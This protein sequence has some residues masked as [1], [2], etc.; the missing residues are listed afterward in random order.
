MATI[1]RVPSVEHNFQLVITRV[2][3]DGDQELLEDEDE[4]E[5]SIHVQLW[6][7]IQVGGHSRWRKSLPCQWRTRVPYWRDRW[8]AQLCVAWSARRRRWVLRICCPWHQWADACVLWNLH[9]P[10]YVWAQ[11]Q[12]K[13]RRHRWCCLWRIYLAVCDDNSR[14][15][16]V[17]F[18]RCITGLLPPRAN[19]LQGG[20]F[21][22]SKILYPCLLQWIPFPLPNHHHQRD[23]PKG[24]LRPSLRRLHPCLLSRFLSPMKPSYTFGIW[25]MKNSLIKASSQPRSCNKRG[26]GS[27][28]GWLR[29]ATTDSY[30]RTKSLKIWTSAGRIRCS[31]SPG[32][33][34][35]IMVHNVVGCS[36]LANRLHTI[37]FSAH[38][39][40]PCGKHSIK[41]H[42]QISRCVKCCI[43][44]DFVPQIPPQPDEQNYILSSNN[45]DVEMLDVEDEEEDEEEV[46]SELDPDE[47]L[48]P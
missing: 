2:Y 1:R 43:L 13:C 19:L 20:K 35:V 31:H 24:Q 28:T 46:L 15:F 47:G 11:V 37:L 25:R 33:I 17:S 10:S 39:C 4:S 23:L 48:S 5:W 16:R 45:E 40:N 7:H 14:R 8:G 38:L 3:E 29:Q 32:T 34:W 9:V 30:S 27:N 26:V 36:G 42:G 18:I 21:Q 44:L 12:N 6:I 22:Q 41:L